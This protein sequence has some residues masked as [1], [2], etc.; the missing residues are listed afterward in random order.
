M[1]PLTLREIEEDARRRLPVAIR[2]FIDGGSS[3]ER[4]L[5]GNL[6]QYGRWGF[7]P[8][9]LVD[10]STVD[11]TVDLLGSTLAAP[12]GV[13]PMAYHRLVDPEGETATARA[14]GRHGLLTVVAMFASRT[15]E[16][17]AAEATGPLWLQLYW[18]RRRD[19]LAGLLE[20][21]E[22]AGYRALLLT[23][24]AP[25]IGRRLRD[26][27]NGFAVPP[28][29]RAVNLEPELMTSTGRSAVGRSAIATHAEEQFETTLTWSDLAWLRERTSLPLVLKGILTA[30][31]ARL[32]VGHGADAVVVSNHGGRQLD[33]AVPT[34]TG[35]PEVV[36]AVPADFP[37]LLDGGVRSGTDAATA[38]ALGARAV[39]VGRPVLWG[40]AAGGEAGAARVLGLL[41]DELEHTLA[42]LGRPRP[43]DL[44]R[45]ALADL[46]V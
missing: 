36:A 35:L 44:D 9:V 10:V 14:A 23:V 30:E 26:L 21:A 32:A 20:R 11:L 1:D 19:V 27:R 39:L 43:G 28:Q 12:I 29:V 2:E 40:L 34:L 31:D 16:E 13:A 15:V 4:T 17:I 5:A 38:L 18:L 41:R 42:L 45:S 3:Q 8:R 46:G 22:Q 33:G 25:R 7:R 6:S 24:D 37:V